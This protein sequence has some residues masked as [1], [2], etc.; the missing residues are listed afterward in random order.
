M[1]WQTP[2]TRQRRREVRALRELKTGRSASSEQLCSAQGQ[3]PAY[4]QYQPRR[5]YLYDAIGRLFYVINV[6]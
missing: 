2:A 4:Y 5:L 6:N 3:S 1:N